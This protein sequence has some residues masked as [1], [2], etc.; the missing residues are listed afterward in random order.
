MTGKHQHQDRRAIRA[1]QF[2]GLPIL[3]PDDCSCGLCG[4]L[5]VLDGPDGLQLVWPYDQRCPVHDPRDRDA[6]RPTAAVGGAPSRLQAA[7][8]IWT[9]PKASVR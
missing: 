6:S 5:V 3:E 8:E 1:C 9:Q 4:R 7:T 2:A